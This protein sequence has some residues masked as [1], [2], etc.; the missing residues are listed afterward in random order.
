[1]CAGAVEYHIHQKFAHDIAR[2]KRMDTS[3]LLRDLVNNHQRP[4]AGGPEE[5]NRFIVPHKVSP[6]L[7]KLISLQVFLNEHPQREES[8]ENWQTKKKSARNEDKLTW[9]FLICSVFCVF[10]PG[11][12]EETM[13][14]RSFVRNGRD[15][16]GKTSLRL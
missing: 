10:L 14:A 16:V 5:L 8:T 12:S 11:V 6:H 9:C 1:M 3:H 2:V 4:V 13:S 7:G 15:G